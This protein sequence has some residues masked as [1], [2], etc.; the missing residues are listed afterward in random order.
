VRA[1]SSDKGR[2][3][4]VA[5]QATALPH[6]ALLSGSSLR[7]G[8]SIV[9]RELHAARVGYA[10]DRSYEVCTLSALNAVDDFCECGY[11]G[12]SVVALDCLNGV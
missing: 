4:D 7:N 2:H 5:L 10:S 6:G 3:S 9:S 12:G 8:Y 11:G 1:E